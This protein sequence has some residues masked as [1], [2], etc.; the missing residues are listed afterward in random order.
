MIYLVS[1]QQDIH[2]LEQN[3]QQPIRRTVPQ[4]VLK[5][6][7]RRKFLQVDSESSGLDPHIDSLHTLQLG[8]FENQFVIDVRCIPISLFKELLESKYC[9]LH[10]AKHD[11]K[12][13]RKAGII[14]DKVY[15]TMLAECLIYNGYD[16]KGYTLQEVVSRHLKIDLNK[17]DRKLFRKLGSRPLEYRHIVY[18]AN[19]VKYL[20]DIMGR[21]LD[22][23]K[24][25]DL[26]YALKLENQALKP[27]GDIEYNGIYLDADLWKKQAHRVGKELRRKQR[28]FDEYLISQNVGYRTNEQG[29]MF[30]EVG[31]KLDINYNSPP[32]SLDM[33]RRLG[34]P[35]NGT[36]EAAL[37]PHADHPAVKK[38]WDVRSQITSLSRY[39]LKFLDHINEQTGRVHTDF[40]QIKNTFRL[41]S[42]DPNMQNI[43]RDPAYRGAFRP[44]PGYAFVSI[45][46]SGQEMRLMADFSEE[47]ALIDAINSG[48]DAHC[49][50]ATMMLGETITKDDPRRQEVKPINFGKPYGMGP[51][52]LARKLNISEEEAKRKL[53]LHEKTFP[54]LDRYLKNQGEK[55]KKQ[56]YVVTNPIH[57]GRRW[58]PLMRAA[59]AERSKPNPNWG[60]VYR[61]EGAVEREAM[62]LSIQGTGAVIIKHALVE[63]RKK[64]ASADAQLINT[65]HD[66]INMEI[67][68]SIVEDVAREVANTMK[69]V[70]EVYVKH[71]QMPVDVTIGDRW[72][73]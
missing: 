59:I 63:V 21:Q 39:G 49:F 53:Q 30:S 15:D 48:K 12:L 55:G 36:S 40:W 71:L 6:F 41:G 1:T 60:R 44:R 42:S 43:P 56:G 64:L 20:E 45:D 18:A 61:L 69:Q 67:H 25:Y 13:F 28:D 52:K 10:N 11:Y 22:T 47:W 58:F 51:P 54:A 19:D 14:L 50:V 4:K 73:K 27:L 57:K 33:L 68:Q 16:S 35:V 2:G 29:D 5:Y 9:L 7:S 66:E 26:M 37:E 8:D 17:D 70:G 24:S 62:N 23:L 3:G 34:L 32:Q 72:K 31:R 46:Y 38:L 65:V